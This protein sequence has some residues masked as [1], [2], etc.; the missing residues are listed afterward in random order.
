MKEQ[1]LHLNGHSFFYRQQGEGP[2]V[3]LLHGFGED[4]SVWQAQYDAFPDYQLL[5]P[6]LPGS[7]KSEAIADMSMEGQAA[8]LEEWLGKTG[9]QQV[10]MIGHSMGGYIALAFAERFPKRLRGLGL[11]HSTAHADTEEKK[12]TRRKGIAFIKE[13]GPAAFLETMIPNL[14]G[15]LTKEKYGERIRQHLA[16]ANN[17]SASVLV[18]YYEAMMARPDRTAVL[19]NTDLPV[20]IISGKDDSV[21]PV[22][23]SMKL[24]HLPRLS[25][26]HVLK[27]S[28]HMGMAE[29]GEESNRLLKDFLDSLENDARPE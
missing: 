10:V 2:A 23:D 9:V 21:I 7:G 1:S 13:H 29:E 25:Y 28:G 17:F 19:Q 18:S 26:I 22:E 16:R 3:V 8:I 12:E 27:Q 24:A 6:D 4:G 20:L 5:I 15:G 11:F 14:Y